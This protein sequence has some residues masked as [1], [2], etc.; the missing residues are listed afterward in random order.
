MSERALSIVFGSSLGL[1]KMLKRPNG[2]EST[3]EQEN[4]HRVRAHLQNCNSSSSTEAIR[5]LYSSPLNLLRRF[6]NGL[7]RGGHGQEEPEV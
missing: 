6:I 2:I 7:N 4:F 5:G 1:F 3:F